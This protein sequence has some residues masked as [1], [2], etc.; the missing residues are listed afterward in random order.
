[1]LQ[2]AAN[3]SMLFANRPLAERF[4]AAGAAG[5]S[6]VEIQFPYALPKQQI[7]AEL[8]RHGLQLVLHN[9]P[10]GNWEAGERGI[11]C[12]PARVA[13]FRAGVASALDYAST[14]A[15]PR[16]NCLA[17]KLPA[18]VS[19]AEARSTLLENLRYAAKAL[20]AEGKTLLLEPINSHDIPGF[21]IDGSQLGFDL[22]AE[23][24]MPNLLL[25]YDV[26]HMT[27]MGEPV[28]ATLTH[29]LGQIGHIQIADVPG[30]GEPG[31]G[32]IDFVTLFA[33]LARQ[34]YG[35]FIGCEY[36]P[37]DGTPAALGWR[38][39]LPGCR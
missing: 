11:A 9:L 8:E 10:A 5:F 1:M 38:T 13:E 36:I 24:A 12:D 25:Q 23:C 28:A 21:L 35:G 33:Q 29:H 39:T 3:L 27:R 19:F 32:T 4:A 20:Q 30:R 17:G 7:R 34:G 16:L 2:F 37:Q 18:G 22:I 26:Y 31:S 14:L 6:A 15:C